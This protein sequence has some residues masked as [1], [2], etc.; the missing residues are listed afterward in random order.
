MTM[1]RTVVIRLWRLMLRFAL[2]YT[3]GDGAPA[4]GPATKIGF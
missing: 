4:S 1:K 2:L 3:D